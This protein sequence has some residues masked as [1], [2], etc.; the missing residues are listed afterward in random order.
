MQRVIYI[1]RNYR[2]FPFNL[3]HKRGRL[4][5][6]FINLSAKP[7][8]QMH[9][10]TQTWYMNNYKNNVCVRT[11]FLSPYNFSKYLYLLKLLVSYI[12]SMKKYNCFIS[13]IWSFNDTPF[14]GCYFSKA[15]RFQSIA[16]KFHITNT[17]A[18]Y[19]TL[20]TSLTF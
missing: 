14:E 18:Y 12:Y 10:F 4:I 5:N 17:T 1:S 20:L 13:L 6:T 8:Y 15:L 7:T 16:L 2:N 19:I 9:W 11:F 3:S